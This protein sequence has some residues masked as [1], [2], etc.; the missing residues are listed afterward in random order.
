MLDIPPKQEGLRERKRRETL[1]RISEAGLELFLAKGYEAT[2]LDEI[3][4]AAGIS[5]R[6]FFYYFESKDELLLAYVG[7]YAD[8][9]KALVLESSSAGEPIDVVRDALVK[10]SSRFNER[11]MIATTRLMRENEVLRARNQAQHLKFEQAVTDGLS[12]LWPRKDRRDRLRVVAM[13][14][15]GALRLAVDAWL[16]QDGKRPLVKHIEEVFRNLRAEI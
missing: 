3:A 4:A 2:T 13:M 16:E 15:M 1:Q 10:L 14:A 8:A 9:L 7:G 5:R 12:K 6:T 11:K